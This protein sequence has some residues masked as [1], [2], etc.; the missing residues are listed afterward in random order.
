[1]ST[2]ETLWTNEQVLD[3]FLR[4]MLIHI[5]DAAFKWREVISEAA[6]DPNPERLRDRLTE[7]QIA[8]LTNMLSLIDGTNGP[9]YWPGIK[10]V[11][12]QNYTLLSDDLCWDL[13]RMESTML[14]LDKPLPGE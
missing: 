2:L 8:V 9:T 7:L 1:M 3:E 5:Q 14:G 6:S 10:L 11:N 4:T 12:A 13:S